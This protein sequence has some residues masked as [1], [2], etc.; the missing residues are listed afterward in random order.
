MKY[1]LVIRHAKAKD[2]EPFQ[3]DFD[4][5]LKKTGI[6]EALEIGKA[7]KDS[8]I[9]VEKFYVSPAKRT[10]ET[11]K[12]IA[13]VLDISK[14][15]IIFQPTIYAAHLNHLLE[16]IHNIP[17]DISRVALIGHNPAISEL[18]NYFIPSRYATLAT[19]ETVLLELSIDDWQQIHEGIAK[20][21]WNRRPTE[22]SS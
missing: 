5:P 10:T 12:V 18:V 8:R 11:A 13:D 20:I 16:L 9:L 3:A 14:E 2:I 21:V 6:S 15:H 17:N 19:C 7:L 4:R 1:L 22:I